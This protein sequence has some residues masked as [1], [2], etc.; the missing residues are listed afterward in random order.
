MTNRCLQILM[1]SWKDDRHPRHGGAEVYT[2][3]VL[4]GLIS[5]GMQATW[6]TPS[7]LGLPDE[8]R[9][10]GG[11]RIIRRGTRLSQVMH[12]WRFLMRHQHQYDLVIDQI[13][14]MPM[15]TRLALRGRPGM[16]LIHQLAADVWPYELP[17]PLAWI[18]ARLEP[19][20]LRLYRT[21]PAVAV[22]DS[23]AQDLR[24]LG[25]RDVSVVKNALTFALPPQIVRH[26]PPAPH[27]VAIGRLVRMKRFE[28]LLAAFEVVRRQHPEARLTII[29]RA[30]GPYAQRLARQISR[31]GGAHLLQNAPEALKQAHLSEATAIVATSVREGWGLMVTEAH[32][33][34][35]P[36]V[37]YR[38]PGLVDST[39]HEVT[40]L[41]CDPAPPAL[42]EAMLAI[43]TDCERWARLSRR[44]AEEASLLTPEA[45][46]A[47]FAAA[48]ERLCCLNR[49]ASKL[50]R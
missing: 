30:G 15:M 17:Y 26:Q 37:A 14:T 3:I 11:I 8:E 5:L 42:A 24:S 43:H 28:H 6:L 20:L 40:G 46:T 44:A 38:V 9:S 41:L 23:T 39:R 47:A 34:G 48:I 33:Y 21:W 27:F 45:T 19:W 32:A 7:A 31:T 49:N 35:T 13:N 1:V 16:V 4:E 50:R 36:S 29:G 25:F 2:R 10:P 18:G 22:S 12:V